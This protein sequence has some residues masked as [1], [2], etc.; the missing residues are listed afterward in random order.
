MASTRTHHRTADHDYRSGSTYA[1][2]CNRLGRGL[3]FPAWLPGTT[4][5]LTQTPASTKTQHSRDGSDQPVK[6][7]LSDR[8]GHARAGTRGSSMPAAGIARIADSRAASRRAESP[9]CLCKSPFGRCGAEASFGTWGLGPLRLE[10]R[11]WDRPARAGAR[12]KAIAPT[13]ASASRRSDVGEG[14]REHGRWDPRKSARAASAVETFRDAL[15]RPR[16]GLALGI[17]RSHPDRRATGRIYRAPGRRCTV[18]PLRLALVDEVLLR[19]G[20]RRMWLQQEL[21]RQEDAVEN[22]KAELHR[23]S[24]RYSR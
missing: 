23:P 1:P 3:A 4:S 19:R 22:V 16:R 21:Q 12:T 20:P 9:S 17:T 15:R 5:S 8:T 24:S 14:D 11:H 13:R 6:L 18:R 2:A 10:C 7:P